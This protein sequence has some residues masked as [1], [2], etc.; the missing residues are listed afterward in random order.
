MKLLAIVGI[1]LLISGCGASQSEWERFKN[2]C[3]KHGG[4]VAETAHSFMSTQY[5]CIV[6]NKI[7]YLPGFEP[8]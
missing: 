8:K 1:T 5:E 7:L 6:D 2:E 3:A 4:F